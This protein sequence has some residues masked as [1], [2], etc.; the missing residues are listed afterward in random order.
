MHVTFTVTR[1][2]VIGEIINARGLTYDITSFLEISNL[3]VND[4]VHQNR[5]EKK[6]ASFEFMR[7][8]SCIRNIYYTIDEEQFRYFCNPK[9]FLKNFGKLLNITND[10]KSA[11]LIEIFKKEES[12]GRNNLKSKISRCSRQ[13]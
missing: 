6:F 4:D 5:R 7:E 2:P 1:R 8:H 11:K 12:N 9:L 3:Y 13:F 10:K